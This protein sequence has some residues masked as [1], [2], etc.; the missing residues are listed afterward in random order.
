M[1]EV[2]LAAAVLGLLAGLLWYGFAPEIQGD[3]TAS[4]VSIPNAEARRQFGM[5]GWF[6]VIAAGGGLL[7]GVIFFARHRSRPATALALLTIGGLAAATVQ[8]WFGRFLGPGPVDG[9]AGLPA[10]TAISMPLELHASAALL[11][12]PIAAVVGALLVAALHDDRE[13]WSARLSRRGRSEPSS[14]P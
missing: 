9:S 7:L 14:P 2:V 6:A 4:G 10:G 12:W 11:V 13:P 3:V 5:D 8:W 1:G